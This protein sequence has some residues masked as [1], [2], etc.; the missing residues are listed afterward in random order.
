V[1]PVNRVD[2][3]RLHLTR[4]TIANSMIT[5]PPLAYF[6]RIEDGGAAAINAVLRGELSPAQAAAQIQAIA[7]DALDAGP[8]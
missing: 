6:P 1:V 3:Q 7:L 4:Q 2:A 5:Y 8:E